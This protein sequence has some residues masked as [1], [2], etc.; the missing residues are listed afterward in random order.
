MAHIINR[1]YFYWIPVAVV[2][3]GIL[4]GGGYHLFYGF[5][6][7]SAGSGDDGE[8]EPENPEVP[9]VQVVH[10][11]PGGMDRTTTQPGTVIAYESV[12]IYAAVPGYLKK[13][14]VDIGSQV[15]KGD[16]LAVIDV[17]ELV[18]QKKLNDAAVKR[19]EKK[20]GQVQA[21][22]KVY[23]ADLV[24]AKAQVKQARAAAKTAETM[25]TFHKHRFE[26]LYPLG[27]KGTVDAGVVDE[28]Q[29]RYEAA[30]EN[31]NAAVETV[32]AAIARETAA[33]AKILQ[34]EA[35]IEE[36]QAAVEVAEAERDKTQ[37]L[38]DYATIVAPFDG[39]ITQRSVFEK[40]FIRAATNNSV[41][42]PL[43]TV[44]RTDKVRVVVMVPDRDTVYTDVG[45]EA[46]IEIDA[47][48]GTVFKAPIARKA[49]AE[50]PKSR[51]MK[52]EIDLDNPPPGRLRSG[53]Y[54]KVTII[55]EKE[56]NV[57]AL[58]AS[59]IF[60]MNE[61][62][63]K[64]QVY[65]VRKNRAVLIQVAIV[66]ESGSNLG[67]VGLKSTDEVILN[68]SLVP[69]GGMEVTVA[70]PQKTGKGAASKGVR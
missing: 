52:V 30:Q 25:L 40:H 33:S 13:L 18:L 37:Q 39:K 70:R 68:P 5:S 27:E 47:I 35:D 50:D 46:T 67:I 69:S 2:A 64:G 16:V 32:N 12:P 43:L 54:G 66:G 24:A 51:S 34:A 41:L 14:N 8:P 22:K 58:P 56:I 28:A 63:S 29:Q 21:L 3:L 65:V 11:Q 1:R 49:E 31:V 57:L 61:Y 9:I 59:C 62:K 38:V 6:S 53:M 42:P 23:E 4:I 10:P 55:L 17:P 19:S 45:D 48:P 7:A 60:G 36:A 15:K 44:E 26:R 20:V